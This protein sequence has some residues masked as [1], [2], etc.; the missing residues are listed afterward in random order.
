[1]DLT[2]GQIKQ[3]SA[4]RKRLVSEKATDTDEQI[5][6]LKESFKKKKIVKDLNID[7]NVG[8]PIP[9]TSSESQSLDITLDSPTEKKPVPARVKSNLPLQDNANIDLINSIKGDNSDVN[10]LIDFTFS[11]QATELL[12]FHRQALILI[13]NLLGINNFYKNQI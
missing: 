12:H 11:T 4:L 9:S 13:Q 1:M 5:K 2:L 10:E 6:A 8:K 7:L 3:I